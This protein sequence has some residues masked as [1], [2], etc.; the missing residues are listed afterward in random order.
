MAAVAVAASA[1]LQRPQFVL[2]NKN[3]FAT[4]PNA[5]H[6]AD[7]G[8]ITN[9]SFA[10]I[11][12]LLPLSSPSGTRRLGVTFPISLYAT[13]TSQTIAFV[14]RLLDTAVANG[15]AVGLALDSF[16]FWDARPDLW[17]WFDASSPGYDPA[18]VQNVEWTSWDA[19]NATAIAWR[20]W[21]SQFRVPPHPNLASPAVIA[22]AQAALSPVT[23]AIAAWLAAA[24]PSQ[25]AALAYVKVRVDAGCIAVTVQ[26]AVAIAQV[27]WEVAIGTNYYFYPGGNA[28]RPLPPSHDPTTGIS[29]SVQVWRRRCGG[30]GS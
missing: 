8:S 27:G 6:Q 23:D 14:Q 2:V 30:S 12:A 7:P 28:L 29:H 25:Q 21:G 9:A 1:Q 4:D 16:E 22:A 3:P 20:N 10:E 18:N 13:T 11:A 19:A 24:S 26:A 15:F 5:W 17:N